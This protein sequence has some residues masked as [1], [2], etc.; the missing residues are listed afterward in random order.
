MGHTRKCP[1]CNNIVHDTELDDRCPLCGT[2]LDA[3]PLPTRGLTRQPIYSEAQRQS[4]SAKLFVA[5]R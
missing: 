2:T 3:A 4:K 5:H 1:H